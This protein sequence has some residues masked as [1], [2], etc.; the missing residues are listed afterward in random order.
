[1]FKKLLG[2]DKTPAPPITPQVSRSGPAWGQPLTAYLNYF[3]LHLHE[4][5]NDRVEPIMRRTY[6]V[7]AD[8]GRPSILLSNKSPWLTVY[9]EPE[10]AKRVGFNRLAS[11]IA[12]EIDDWVIGYRIYAGEGMDVHFFHSANHL[13]QLALAEDALAYEP[14]TVGLFSPLADVSAIVPR[15]DAQHPLDFHFALL[16]ALGIGNASLV[17]EEALDRHQTGTLE[18]SRL[19]AA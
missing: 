15:P 19:L 18:D 2:R 8:K 5:D 16:H 12:H 3:N 7:S 14:L 9:V 11:E 17:W 13:D 6:L 4:V 10:L 1:M